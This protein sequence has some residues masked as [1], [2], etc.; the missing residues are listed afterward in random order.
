MLE[1]LLKNVKHLAKNVLVMV[2]LVNPLLCAKDIKMKLV[3]FMEQMVFVDGY[4]RMD[5]IL[6]SVF[7]LKNVNKPP[8]QIILI[9]NY[10]PV[11]V[12]NTNIQHVLI[13]LNV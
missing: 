1:L 8:V 13:Y 3:V 9:V 10:F 7:N 4:H 6:Q 12:I 5:Q 2:Q 11:H